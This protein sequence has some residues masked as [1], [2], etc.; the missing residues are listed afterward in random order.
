M[1]ALD[2]A[3]S[4]MLRC[5]FDQE[6]FKVMDSWLAQ[7]GEAFGGDPRFTLHLHPVGRWGGANDGELVVMEDA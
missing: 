3:L 1:K 7:L 4:V 5:N 2:R 6:N